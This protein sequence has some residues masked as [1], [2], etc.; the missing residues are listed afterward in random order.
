MAARQRLYQRAGFTH[1]VLRRAIER[2]PLVDLVSRLPR[3]RGAGLDSYLGVLDRVLEDRF[4]SDAELATVSDLA[5]ELGLTRETAE[6]AH[7]EYLRH[8]CEAAWRDGQVTEPERA[9]LLEVARLIG[10]PAAEALAI[11]DDAAGQS[12]SRLGAGST[13]LVP[14]D[15]VLLTG[16]MGLPRAQIEALAAAAGLRVTGSASSKTTLVVTSDPYSQS[17]KARQ[18]G[19]LGVRMVTDQ[20]FLHMLDE[21]EP[22]TA[23]NRAYSKL[24]AQ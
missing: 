9:D 16:D 11:L 22:D 1:Q 7:W 6:Q 10:V 5:A 13:G 24:Q 8:V 20:V 14:G 23:R 19:E 15:R 3:G 2:P 18:A 17:G 21:M 12:A 4:V